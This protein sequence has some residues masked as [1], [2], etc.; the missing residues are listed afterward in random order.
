MA[1]CHPDPRDP[2]TNPNPGGRG[3]PPRRGSTGGGLAVATA[4]SD[5]DPPAPGWYTAWV[6]RT[7]LRDPRHA[8]LLAHSLLSDGLPEVHTAPALPPAPFG[9]EYHVG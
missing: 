9:S 5:P 6:A 7:I 1:P 3:R 8:R 2:K 4:A